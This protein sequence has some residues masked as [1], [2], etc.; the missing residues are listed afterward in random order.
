LL[1]FLKQRRGVKKMGERKTYIINIDGM[2]ADY[3]NATGHQGC[4]TPTLVDLAKQGI[5]FT[6]CKDIMPANTGTNHTAILTGTHAGSHGILGVGGYYQ[7]LDFNHLRFSRFYGNPKAGMYGHQHLQVPTFFNIAKKN[8]PMLINAFITSKTWLGN[9]L[10]DQDC[11]ITIFPG[12]TS[13][14]CGEHKPNS[15][16]VTPPKDYVIGGLAHAEDNEILPRYYIPKKGES[17]KEPSGTI[18]TGLVGIDAETLPSDQWVIDQAITCLEQDDPDFLYMV[19][20]NMDLAGHV[21]GAFSI[22]KNHVRN[23][24]ENLSPLRNPAA[25]KDQLY[26]TDQEIK[27]FIDYLK[28]ND[29]FD[30]ARIIITSDHGMNTMKSVLSRVS[31]KN[32]LYWLQEKLRSTTKPATQNTTIGFPE[33]E[34]LDVDIRRILAKHGIRMRASQGKWLQRYNPRGEYDWCVSDG[35]ALGYIYNASPT[36]QKKIKE[37]LMSYE[38]GENGKKEHPVWMVLTE[39]DMDDA[40]NDYT[41]LPFHLG[42]GS[43]NEEYDGIWPSVIVFP[44]PHFVVPFYN[45]QLRLGLTSLMLTINLPGFIDMKFPPGSH[46]TYLEQDVPLLFVSPSEPEIP[47]DATVV[48]QVSVLDILPTITMLNEWPN[49]PSFEGINILPLTVLAKKS[50]RKMI[51]RRKTT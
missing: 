31:W 33:V 40:I 3:F 46:G 23:N 48:D 1:E 5:R 28:E 38:L 37:I 14:N 24:C 8:N 9:I 17:G 32:M 27:R 45:D 21:Y 34:E 6:N 41:G 35:I 44:N 51:E 25:I 4:L 13:N 7:G 16:Y 2:R 36:V 50:N 10:A 18:S 47:Q 11:D 19:L 20:M 29:L 12:N 15:D 49:Q 22:D 39:E 26:L 42:Q 43:F 30:N